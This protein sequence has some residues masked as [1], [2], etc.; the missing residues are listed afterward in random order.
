MKSPPIF[1]RQL[2]MF[3]SVVS[4]N[5]DDDGNL[6]SI[7]AMINHKPETINHDPKRLMLNPTC[8]E[9]NKWRDNLKDCPYKQLWNWGNKEACHDKFEPLEEEMQYPLYTGHQK[10]PKEVK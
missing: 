10:Q 4:L 5:F 8:G 6:Y 7:V 2:R 3:L 1:D 9:R